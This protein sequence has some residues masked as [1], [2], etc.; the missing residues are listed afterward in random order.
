VTSTTLAPDDEDDDDAPTNMISAA[1]IPSWLPPGDPIQLEPAAPTPAPQ[2]EPTGMEEETDAEQ[3]DAL[4]EEEDNEDELGPPTDNISAAQLDDAPQTV[5]LSENTDFE[6][7]PD[8][9]TQ[10]AAG[11]LDAQPNLQDDLADEFEGEGAT[12][13]LPSYVGPAPDQRAPDRPVPRPA[14]QAALQASPV[15]AHVSKLGTQQPPA[16]QRRPVPLLPDASALVQQVAPPRAAGGAAG[17]DPSSTSSL[18][19]SS[20]LAFDSGHSGL[21]GRPKPTLLEFQYGAAPTAADP[22]ATAASAALPEGDDDLEGLKTEMLFNP[23]TRDMVAPKL[24]VIEG[25][26][27]GQEFFVNGLKCTV[28]RGENNTLMVA[29]LSMSRH[30]FE[31]VRNPDESFTLRDL[32]SANGTSLQGTRIREAVLF[33]G[34]RIEAGQSAFIFSHA[35]SPPQAHRHMVLAVGET[36]AGAPS[37]VVMSAQTGRMFSSLDQSSRFFTL[38]TLIAGALC[39]PLIGL[40]VYL[41]M[42]TP[43]AKPDTA[44]PAVTSAAPAADLFMQGVQAVKLRE[45]DQAQAYFARAKA[46]A[47][48]LNVAPQLARIER[49]R[50]AQTKLEAAQK[51]G[52][53]GDLDRAHALASEI[54][55]ESVYA[56]DARRWIRRAKVN[57]ADTLYT[58]AQEQFTAEQLDEALATIDSLLKTTPDHQAAAELRSR[59]VARKDEIERLR[60]EQEARAAREALAAAN[61]PADIIKDPF[62]GDKSKNPPATNNPTPTAVQA[63]WNEGMALYK[64][65]KFAEAATFFEKAAAAEQP[66]RAN[67]ARRLATDMRIVQKNWKE[68]KAALDKSDWAGAFKM[69]DL[70]LRADDRIGG[71][72]KKA[73]SELVATSLAKQ[74]LALIGKEDYRQARKLL[75]ESRKLANSSAA[76]ELD[77]ELEDKATSLYIK[78]AAARKAN[79]ADTASALCRTIMLMV[80]SSSPSYSKAQKLL[81][82]L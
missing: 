5:E 40:L 69:L 4:D 38:I 6:D 50:V 60:I 9:R 10:V 44:Q 28:G 35:A 79:D 16:L 54:P 53:S 65:E 34:D 25:P 55:P 23:F 64:S 13:V 20:P 71:A 73:L 61:K 17:Y 1:A 19:S 41:S 37:A 26:A 63:D 82:E 48:S 56:E 68:G 70:A 51:A 74:G 7:D 80:P 18:I 59:V 39:L 14:V 57:E 47:P 58:K 36:V 12:T 32:N 33:D 3:L 8:G 77:R 42:R 49:E 76:A 45:W 31:V 29:D 2:A 75:L 30:H 72:H 66:A 11:L 27:L 81:L 67:K 78:A 52:E 21:N 46:L 15:P 24:R 22:V 43:E 62:S